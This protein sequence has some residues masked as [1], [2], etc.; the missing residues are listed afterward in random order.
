M[1]QCLQDNHYYLP[2]FVST[3]FAG[4]PESGVGS[5][6]FSLTVSLESVLSP[7]LVGGRSINRRR[8]GD[9]DRKDAC[10]YLTW[11]NSAAGLK[12][13]PKKKHNFTHQTRIILYMQ[14]LN[15]FNHKFL[16]F[17][18]L[19]PSYEKLCKSIFPT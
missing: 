15:F 12:C 6:S 2:L 4:G 14:M 17:T 18:F 5:N 3:F 10:E 19:H 11:Q 7:L 16:F 1:S 13:Q 8:L 9:T